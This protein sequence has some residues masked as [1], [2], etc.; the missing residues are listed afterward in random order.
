MLKTME[1]PSKKPTTSSLLLLSLLPFCADAWLKIFKFVFLLLIFRMFIFFLI[2][3]TAGAQDYASE[4][5]YPDDL[6]PIEDL[7]GKIDFSDKI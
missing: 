7:E 6:I 4:V 2:L 5:L 3:L 1:S